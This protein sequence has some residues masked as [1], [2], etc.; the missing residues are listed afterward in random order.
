VVSWAGGLLES[1][2]KPRGS[3][4]PK[5]RQWLRNGRQVHAAKPCQADT[6]IADHGDVTGNIKA[7]LFDS[8]N[9]SH[10]PDVVGNE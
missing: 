1:F 5:L 7:C 10:R 2:Q 8:S 6:V 4:S 9:S 3:Q